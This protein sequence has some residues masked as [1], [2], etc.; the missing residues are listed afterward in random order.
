MSG[1]THSIGQLQS[2]MRRFVKD[3]VP[4]L[5]LIERLDLSLR[6]TASSRRDDMP[7][8]SGGAL[9]DNRAAHEYQLLETGRYCPVI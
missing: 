6:N 3:R 4:D 2:H 7:A 5:R 9:I 1:A 8:Q